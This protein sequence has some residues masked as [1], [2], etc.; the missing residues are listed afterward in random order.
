[1]LEDHLAAGAI[2]DKFIHDIVSHIDHVKSTKKSSKDVHISFDEWN[3]W[4]AS[5]PRN[6]HPT[7]DDWPEAP[8]I[9]E[10]LYTVADAV[11]VGDLLITLLKNTD[12]VHA[13]SLAQLVNVIA[14]IMTRPDGPAW[15]QTTFHPFALTSANAKGEVL[16][17]AVESPSFTAPAHGE[18]QSLSAVATHDSETGRITLFAVNRNPEEKLRLTLDLRAWG[19][20]PLSQAL[21]YS[22]EDPLWYAT[23]E[24]S[25]TVLPEPLKNIVLQDG[26][27]VAEL[28]PISWSM[29]TLG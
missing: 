13:A 12:R 24:D 3:V 23:E 2:M 22:H 17:L 27:L 15:K 19:E 4:H 1:V 21:T 14:P 25:T 10:D 29:I 20:L 6:S 26:E 11:V 18:I 8:P 9:L 28:D 5:Q 7:G 16:R